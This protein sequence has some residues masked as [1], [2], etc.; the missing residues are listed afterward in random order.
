MLLLY[1]LANDCGIS[2]ALPERPDLQ[3]QDIQIREAKDNNLDILLHPHPNP[4][5]KCV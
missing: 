2:I 4:F 3:V 1:V 5:S